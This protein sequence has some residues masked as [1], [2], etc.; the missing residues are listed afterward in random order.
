[1]P[2][3]ETPRAAV[4]R[5]F[6]EIRKETWPAHLNTAERAGIDLVMLDADLAGCVTTWLSNNGVLDARRLAILRRRLSDLEQVMPEID[7][8]DNTRLWQ[9]WHDV[10]QLVCESPTN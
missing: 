3:S 9:L 2:A 5:L 4:A 10:G 8:A 6:Q 7:E 1:M